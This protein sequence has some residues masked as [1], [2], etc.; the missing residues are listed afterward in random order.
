MVL[1]LRIG[2]QHEDWR[3]K[4]HKRLEV[5][6]SETRRLG[7]WR[8]GDLEIELAVVEAWVSDGYHSVADY[9]S[10]FVS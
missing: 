5:G 2:H 1:Y 4:V 9:C 10:F 8:L 7:D 3:A 6:G